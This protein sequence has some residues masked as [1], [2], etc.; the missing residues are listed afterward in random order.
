M[1]Y[2]DFSKKFALKN[3]CEQSN[4]Y[5]S[6]YYLISP[7]AQNSFKFISGTIRKNSDFIF[8]NFKVS[9]DFYISKVFL[10]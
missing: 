6:N 8:D 3:T 10:K 5:K 9:D 4:C 2:D 7:Y 1:Y